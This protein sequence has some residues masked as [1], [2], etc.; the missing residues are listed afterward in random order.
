MQLVED[1]FKLELINGMSQMRQLAIY[2]V[3]RVVVT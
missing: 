3:V 2:F 1:V